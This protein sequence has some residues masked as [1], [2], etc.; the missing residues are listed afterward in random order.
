MLWVLK[1]T[2][3]MRLTCCLFLTQNI[4]CG[5]SKESS[6]WDGSFEHPKHMLK[7]MGKKIFT[8]LCSKFLYIK[9]QVSW[10]GN[11]TITDQTVAM[12]GSWTDIHLTTRITGWC[13]NMGFVRWA[14]VKIVAKRPVI[15][16]SQQVIMG[17]SLKESHCSSYHLFWICQC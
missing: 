15:P 14:V 7:L 17:G 1:R 11:A 8:I 2:V 5:Y 4:C 13:L 3:S 16:L 6:Q 12:Y 10:W 9:S